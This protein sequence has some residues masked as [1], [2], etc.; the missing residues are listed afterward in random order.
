MV[1]RIVIACVLLSNALMALASDATDRTPLVT[2][3]DLQF[4]GFGRVV[5]AFVMVGA[6]AFVAVAI[7]KKIRPWLLRRGLNATVASQISVVSHRRLSRTLNIYLVDVEQQRFMIVQSSSATTV[8]RIDGS[9]SM[10]SGL[11]EKTG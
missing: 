9:N 8:T 3:P 11:T 6:L 1:V 4:P 2:G 10:D 7:L 5:F